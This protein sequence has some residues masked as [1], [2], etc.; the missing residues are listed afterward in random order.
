MDDVARQFPTEQKGDALLIPAILAAQ[1]MDA[2]EVSGD[3]AM[4]EALRAFRLHLG[5]E[6]AFISEFADGRRRFV[7]VDSCSEHP[8]IRVG[9]SDPLEES[10]C[11]RVVDGRLPELIQDASQIPAA[12]E[13]PVTTALPVG[14]H[15][16]VPIR[17]SDGRVY[18]TFCCFSSAPNYTLQARDL[19]MMR[20]FA[21]F[22]ARQIDRRLEAIRARR[23]MTARVRTVL[24]SRNIRMVYQPIYDFVLDRI[25]GFEAL[26]RFA[27]TPSR[28]PDVWFS[29]AAQVGL[30]EEL[31]TRVIETALLGLDQLPEDTYLSLNVSPEHVASGAITRALEGVALDRIV[32]EVTEHVAVSE[33]SP[34]AA[35]L[36]PLRARGLRLAIDDAGAGFASFRHILQLDPNIIKLDMSLIRHIDTDL[37][38]RALAAALIR[39]AEETDSKVIAEGVETAAELRELRRLHV[40][41]AQGYLLGRPMPI[42]DAVAIAVPF[43][44]RSARG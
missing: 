2:G 30:G 32:L 41:M 9:G 8:P 43:S 44:V 18:G 36:E 31:E 42:A 37:R 1:H 28:T 5:M 24:D 6:V 22:A 17:L 26:T 13:L 34:F 27:A 21:D 25:V 29:E 20:V 11:Q 7:H 12:L 39:F 14:A 15:M 19:A 35:M 23:E 3:D 40:R 33:Y 4:R 10:Y 38:R 16:S